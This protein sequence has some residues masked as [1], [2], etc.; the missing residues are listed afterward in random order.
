MIRNAIAEAERTV[1]FIQVPDASR[2]L[3]EGVFYLDTAVEDARD[4]IRMT[5]HYPAQDMDSTSDNLDFPKVWYRALGYML[6]VDLAPEYDIELTQGLALLATDAAMIARTSDP[7]T[8][9]LTFQ[10]AE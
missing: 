2:I 4:T 9:D 5:V 6:A 3:N 7:E 1:V 10:S 8:S